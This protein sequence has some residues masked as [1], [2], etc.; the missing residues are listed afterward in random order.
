MYNLLVLIASAVSSTMTFDEAKALADRYEA[1]AS[2]AQA[3]DFKMSFIKIGRVAFAKCMP[4]P[5]LE[6]VPNFTVVMMVDT[7][8]KV[9][10]TWLDN[11]T[12]FTK[13]VEGKFAVAS[14]P[15]PPKSPFYTS[16]EFVFGTSPN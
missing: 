15:K 1:T 8:G 4:S 7:T 5:P 2:A 11:A 6:I 3:D 12:D 13:C 10:N 14:L 9:Q 16:F